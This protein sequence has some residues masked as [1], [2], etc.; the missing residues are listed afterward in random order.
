MFHVSKSQIFHRFMQSM[1]Q[2]E[3]VTWFNFDISVGCR[4]FAKGNR[5]LSKW[6]DQILASIRHRFT[7][8]PSISEPQLCCVWARKGWTSSPNRMNAVYIYCF[9]TIYLQQYLTIKY[10]SCYS[11]IVNHWRGKFRQSTQKATFNLTLKMC[12]IDAFLFT[13]VRS[14]PCVD[15][16]GVCVCVSSLFAVM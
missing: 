6:V 9:T 8:F 4:L 1:G 16:L 14:L 11:F 7:I 12:I 10:G 2:N 3:W 5:R 15:D 13:S